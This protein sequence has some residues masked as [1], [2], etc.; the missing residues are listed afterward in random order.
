MLWTSSCSHSDMFPLDKTY[1]WKVAL[2]EQLVAERPEHTIKSLPSSRASVT[3]MY[4]WTLGV[5]LPRKMPRHFVRVEEEQ[6]MWNR[7]TDRKWPLKAPEDIDECLR[8]LAVNVETDLLMME[9]I[10][11]QDS[12]HCGAWVVRLRSRRT[13]S[14]QAD[15]PLSPGKYMLTAICACFP[16]GLNFVDLIGEP[17][18][19]VR[20]VL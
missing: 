8:I 20:E 4:E 5:Y 19:K 18:A 7:V 13:S 2:R 12:P 1:P 16:N 14:R 10:T 6:V 11:D 15:V 9:E 17:L 3:E